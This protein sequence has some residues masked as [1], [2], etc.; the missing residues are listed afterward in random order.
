[1]KKTMMKKL[2]TLNPKEILKLFPGWKHKELPYCTAGRP[3]YSSEQEKKYEEKISVPFLWYGISSF[4]TFERMI[5]GSTNFHWGMRDFGIKTKVRI[6]DVIINTTNVHKSESWQYGTKFVTYRYYTVEAPMKR[7][8]KALRD[9]KVPR[10]VITS[11]PDH[12]V[13]LPKDELWLILEAVTDYNHDG[14]FYLG[15]HTPQNSYSTYYYTVHES[16]FE[17]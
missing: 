8:L 16:N 7:V 4:V 3:S 10:S 1:M 2:E 9:N 11:N 12:L 6:G 14:F 13:Y 5:G 17:K 15:K